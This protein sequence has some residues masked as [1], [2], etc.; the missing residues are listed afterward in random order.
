MQALIEIRACVTISHQIQLHTITWLSDGRVGRPSLNAARFFHQCNGHIPLLLLRYSLL[1]LSAGHAFPTGRI[2]AL[3][4]P[5]ISSL[6]GT[7]FDIFVSPGGASSDIIPLL[8]RH[9]LYYRWHGYCD[10]L[11]IPVRVQTS[12]ARRRGGAVSEQYACEDE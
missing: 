9:R 10:E 11:V 6:R 1:S 12:H 3:L 2:T 5:T 4:Y 8:C 7:D